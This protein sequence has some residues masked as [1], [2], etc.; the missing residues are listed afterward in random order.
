MLSLTLTEIVDQYVRENFKRILSEF[1]DSPL[2]NGQWVLK[3]YTFTAAVTNQRL[4]HGLSFVPVD[5]ILTSKTGSGSLTVN[6]AL[7]D[8]TYLD[9][10]TSGACVVRLL[11]G[12]GSS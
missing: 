4:P 3:T 5:V 11:I 2:L 8:K 6:Y 9:L 7:I 12:R 1:T 10:T